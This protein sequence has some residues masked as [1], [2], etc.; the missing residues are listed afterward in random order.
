MSYS[1][2]EPCRGCGST[3]QCWCQEAQEKQDE[4]EYDRGYAWACDD[5]SEGHGD[6]ILRET[7]DERRARLNDHGAFA[8]HGADPDT[9]CAGYF[10]RVEKGD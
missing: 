1:F 2:T 8:L 7:A 5:F 4:L 10:A 9:F 6:W 3:G